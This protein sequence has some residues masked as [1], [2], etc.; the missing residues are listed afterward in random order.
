MKKLVLLSSFLLSTVLA[1]SQIDPKNIK[2]QA[3]Q[4]SIALLAGDY[5]TLV[6][7]T[8]PEVVERM[9]G[10]EKMIALVK[11]GR[12]DLEG[13]GIAID[14]SMVGDP[15]ATV[16][17]GNEIHCLVPQTVVLTIPKGKVRS[18]SYLIGISQDGGKHWYFIDTAQ[19]TMANVKDVLPNYN[20]DLVIPPAK[21]PVVTEN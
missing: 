13:Q 11:R 15:S 10:A 2:D 7:H 3:M 14:T 4:L 9:G 18:E 21:S 8:Y 1:H 16:T 20:M 19:I 12:A 5:P 6:K 17:A